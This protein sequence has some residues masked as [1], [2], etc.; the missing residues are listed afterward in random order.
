MT[1]TA[2]PTLAPFTASDSEVDMVAFLQREKVDVVVACDLPVAQ[3]EAIDSAARA[4]GSMFYGAGTYG[5]FGWVF[6]DLG[7]SYDYVVTPAPTSVNPNPSLVKKRAAYASLTSALQQDHWALSE[8]ETASGGSAFRGLSRSESRALQPQLAINVLAVWEFS[9]RHGGALPAGAEGEQAE[10]AGIAEEMRKALGVHTKALPSVDAE[11]IAHL[12]QHARRLF[13]PTL[14]IVGGLL[15][16]DVLRTLSRKDTP[17]ANLLAVD[18]MGGNGAVSRWAMA[19]AVDE[20][21]A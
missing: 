18:T 6:A 2:F 21:E 13:A 20:V 14:A 11:I 4:A 10:L 9:K 12:A 15:A 16:Q 8:K 19:P 7:A 5:F 17:I 1:L 3:L